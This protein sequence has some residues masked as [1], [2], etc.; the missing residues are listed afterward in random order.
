MLLS[1]I[2]INRAIADDDTLRKKEKFISA[3]ISRRYNK[4]YRKGLWIHI[5]L[6]TVVPLINQHTCIH[7]GYEF[8]VVVET[9]NLFL[10]VQMLKT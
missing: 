4:S 8:D 1:E 2:S 10:L 9:L 5:A 3:V 7:K 6:I